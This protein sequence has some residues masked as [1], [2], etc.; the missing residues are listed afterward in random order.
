VIGLFLFGGWKLDELSVDIVPLFETITDLQHA[1][2]I[3]RELNSLPE[4][5]QHLQ[6]RGNRQTIMLGFS[7]GTK[8]GGYLMTNWSIYKAKDDLT[9][10]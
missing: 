2:T 10:V 6:R 1:P 8:D 7:N 4:Y 9:R 5:R 3:M